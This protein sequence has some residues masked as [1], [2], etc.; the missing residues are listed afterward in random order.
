MPGQIIHNF[1]IFIFKFKQIQISIQYCK[2]RVSTPSTNLKCS[3]NRNKCSFFTSSFSS[4][5][6]F[7]HKNYNFTI[8]LFLINPFFSDQ[9]AIFILKVSF[10][11]TDASVHAATGDAR[12]FYSNRCFYKPF[13]PNTPQTIRQNI[14]LKKRKK[15][16]Q[17][18]KTN[19]DFYIIYKCQKLC[20]LPASTFRYNN[21]AIFF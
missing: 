1:T 9:I 20:A 18:S 8:S 19:T 17:K 10:P 5:S 12:L 4:E 13:Y 16:K 2:S 7:Y 3:Q 6:H 11:A 21:F 15:Q 14:F